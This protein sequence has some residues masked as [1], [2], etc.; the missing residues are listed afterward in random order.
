M[1][2][3][4]MQRSLECCLGRSQLRT[5]KL[6]LTNPQLL[7]DASG[8]PAPKSRW[9]TEAAT[10]GLPVALGAF[11]E[12]FPPGNSLSPTAGCHWLCRNHPAKSGTITFRCNHCYSVWFGG[13]QKTPSRLC[14]TCGRV[15][16]PVEGRGKPRKNRMV[17]CP[18]WQLQLLRQRKRIFGPLPIR[19]FLSGMMVIRPAPA[20][21]WRT[22]GVHRLP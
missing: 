9:G 4:T 5:R 15:D 1:T 7:R 22:P 10:P 11:L 12:V 6:T 19:A 13:Q 2:A 3:S 20:E 21:S 18:T 14:R 8:L 16:F 17:N